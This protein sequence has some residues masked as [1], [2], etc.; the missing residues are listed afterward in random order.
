MREHGVLARV[1]LI[2]EEC[3]RRLISGSGF[4]PAPLRDAVGIVRRFVEE[5]HEKQEEDHLF[6]LFDRAGK[7]TDLVGVL[8]QQHQAGRRLT[9]VILD[10][11]GR[12]AADTGA[13][14]QLLQAMALFIRTY[15]PHAAREDTVL[16]PALRS[17]IT[18]EAF[19][20]LGETFEDREQQQ[21]GKS[22]FEGIV[23]QVAGIERTLG[24]DDLARFTP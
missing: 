7:L 17:I 6:P 20:E 16:F 24:I 22:G 2:Y 15:R 11:A 8:R 13:G 10:Q 19:A 23:A 4:D 14:Q 21:F 3:G 5:Y 18:A 1:L 9:A 12:A